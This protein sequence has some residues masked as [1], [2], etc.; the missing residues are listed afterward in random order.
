[1]PF[2]RPPALYH[3]WASMKDRCYNKNSKAYPD[4]GGR[5]VTVCERWRGSYT[6]FES[7]MGDRPE[8]TSIDRID[9]NGNYEPSNCKWSTRQEQQRNQRR[10][11]YVTI[12]NT[13]YRAV[14][15]SEKYGL[16]TD[17]IVARAAKGFSFDECVQKEKHQSTD[18]TSAVAAKKAKA[19]A[20]THCRNN[21]ELTP[22]NTYLTKEGWKVCR[23]CHNEKM[24]RL[25]AK[26]MI[27]RAS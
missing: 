26:K 23:T 18:T 27:M 25:T 4:Y 15:L 5:G 6:L 19:A 2:K 14:E 11:V 17:T 7:D 21:H 24:R 9:N 22:E 1:V 13:V 10:A 20:K 12:E 3:V 8:G 16:K